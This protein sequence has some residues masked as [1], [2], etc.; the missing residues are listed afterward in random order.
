MRKIVG[1]GTLGVGV[2][3]LA[4]WGRADQARDMELS[5]QTAADQVV[6][7]SGQA[8]VAKISGRDIE[9]S[10]SVASEEEREAL[11]AQFK[12][13]PGRRAVRAE[14]IEISSGS[15]NEYANTSEVDI[16]DW[17]KTSGTEF[18]A[19]GIDADAVTERLSGKV[20]QLGDLE[21]TIENTDMSIADVDSKLQNLQS[22]RSVISR[23]QLTSE[24]LKLTLE[25][26]T[27][28]S[29][30]KE[31]LDAELDGLPYELIETETPEDGTERKNLL[32][33]FSETFTA[34][35]WIPQLEFDVSLD[36]CKAQTLAQSQYGEIRF[37]SGTAQ[38]DE[39]ARQVV[40]AYAAVMN[41]CFK[42]DESGLSVELAGHTDNEGEEDFNLSLSQD[43]AD[44]V[45][46]ALVERGVAE[47]RIIANGYGESQPIADNSTA[48]GRAENR[49]TELL[50]T[51]GN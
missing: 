48:E 35:N 11:I 41:R 7:Q 17:S 47:D 19:D 24:K 27:D 40:N 44:A 51:D 5:I 6:G 26:G 31:A 37:V 18:A 46:A 12:D 39:R 8:V 34:G 15:S 25:P 29:L 9:L 4:L 13:V 50:W 33:G 30:V 16:I 45:R 21:Q 28:L 22:W 49:R 3:A 38:L 10:G 36:E 32:T 2:V 14:K 23:L 20:A 1:V 43:R 42:D